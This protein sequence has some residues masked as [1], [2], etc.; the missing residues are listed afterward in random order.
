VL[1]YRGIYPPDEDIVEVEECRA[2]ISDKL[3]FVIDC[4]VRWI[5]YSINGGTR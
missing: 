5:I 2:D 4:A 3:L 1:V